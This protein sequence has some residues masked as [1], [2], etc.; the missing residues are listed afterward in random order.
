MKKVVIYV[1]KTGNTGKIANAI[2][3]QIGC[4]AVEFK[5]IE[6]VNLDDFDF[7]G[8]G[9]YVDKGDVESGFK[10]YLKANLKNKKVGVFMTLGADPDHPHA[11]E[12]LNKGKQIL[13]ENGNE[14]LNEFFCQG[15]VSP[16]MIESMRKLGEMMPNDPRFAITPEREARWIR[17]STHPDEIDIQNAKLAFKNL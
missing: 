15:A 13:I 9:F 6:R 2:A 14:I 5:D 8:V 4:E 16:E 1:S 3:E 11:L 10:N 17:A 7:V 12:C